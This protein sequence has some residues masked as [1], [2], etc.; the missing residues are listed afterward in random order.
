[1][2]EPSTQRWPLLPLV[3]GLVVAWAA[4]CWPWLSGKVTVPWDAK[5]HFYPQL[6]FLAQSLAAG[7]RPFWAPFVFSGSPQ[8]ADPQSLIFS[9]PYYLLAKL[10]AAPGFQAADAVPFAMLLFGALAV[11]LYFR[12]RNWHPAGA[13]V[14]ALAFMFGGSAA[15]RIQHVGQVMSLA[16]FPIALWLLDR[17]LKRSS[18][19]YGVMAGLVAG[20]MVLGRDQVAGLAVLVLAAYVLTHLLDG[21]DRAARITAALRPLLAGGIAGAAVVVIPVLMTLLLAAESNRA[22]IDYE[23]AG[24]GSL[25]PSALL[26]GFIANLFGTDGA[27]KDFWGAPSPLWGPVDL[28][29]ARNMSNVYSGA[30]VSLAVVFGLAGGGAL[31]RGGRFFTLA[32]LAMLLYTLGRY[33]PFFGLAYTTIPGVDFFRRP[34]DG[35]FMIGALAAFVAGYVVHLIASRQSALISKPGARTI[36][37]TLAAVLSSIALALAKG[38][39]HYAW[40]M[41]LEGVVWLAA[42]MALMHAF[43]PLAVTRP[44]LAAFAVGA[45][46]LADLARNNGPNESTALP[47]TMFE[48]LK[49]DSRDETVRKLKQLTEASRAPDRIDR[50]ELAAIDFHWPNASLVHRLHNTLGYNPLRDRLYSAATGAGDHVALPDQRGFPPTFPSYVSPLADL[51]G[52]RYIA[53]GVP[54]DRLDRA[55][56]AGALPLVART[57]A[58]YI[59]ENPRALPRVLFATHAETAD[60]QAILRSGHWPRTDFR[61]TVLVEAM[62]PGAPRSANPRPGRATITKYANTEVRIA[63]DSPDGGFLV[64]NDP[65]HPWWYAHIDGDVTELYRANL[66]FRMVVLP[67][68]R[69]EVVFLFRPQFGI[70]GSLADRLSGRA[71]H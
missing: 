4:F 32:L 51:L 63:V 25:H 61:N 20:F 43:R 8:I 37:I 50:V 11:V 5:A 1:M 33:T 68:G 40:P 58:A 10:N 2:S 39:L 34:A 27:F 36:A 65:W 66:L 18:M 22:Y 9:P 64:L 14:A 13:M 26:T 69:H 62:P 6:V 44:L 49:P 67:P 59:Y 60:F 12:D 3:G 29:V 57:D 19:L 35:T 54:L 15:W 38:R 7:E 17:G 16:Y 23:G 71:T 70:V 24:R 53:S 31:Q 48:A 45:F 52:L 47:P 41:I 55:A 42:A 21:P 30:A 56:L 28:Y 46:M